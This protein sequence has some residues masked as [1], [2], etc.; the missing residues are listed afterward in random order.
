MTSS[1]LCGSK[2]G[3]AK[4]HNYDP[5]SQNSPKA[6]ARS[7]AHHQMR[8]K[9]FAKLMALHCHSR[10]NTFHDSRV[11]LQL[12]PVSEKIYFSNYHEI[13]QGTGNLERQ[14]VV[15]TAPA[16]EKVTKCSPCES[17]LACTTGGAELPVIET[18]KCW[19]LA[20]DFQG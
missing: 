10:P 1:L 4:T 8:S 13:A 12:Y 2:S 19:L 9:T 7:R 17:L 15:I 20:F 18:R 5:Q 3:S 11:S 16:I 6:A 14:V